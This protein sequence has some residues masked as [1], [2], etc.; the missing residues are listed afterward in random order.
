M[1]ATTECFDAIIC[2]TGN[3]HEP[4]LPDLPG[5]HTYPGDQLH[6]HNFRSN[7]SYVGKTV[8]IVGAAFSGEALWHIQTWD[9]LHMLSL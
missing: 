4:N 8:L 3:Y 1:Q 7:A 2:V 9:Q 5:I 6:C